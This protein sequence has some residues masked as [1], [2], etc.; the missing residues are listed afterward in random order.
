MDINIPNP[1]SYQGTQTSSACLSQ[2]HD[3]YKLVF[4]VQIHDLPSLTRIHIYRQQDRTHTR[5]HT[6]DLIASRPYIYI[7][8]Y[9]YDYIHI[10]I[11]TSHSYI[12]IYQ[13]HGRRQ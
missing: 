12:Y 5:T 13:P 11:S 10:Y 1:C 4:Q 9:I 8:I 6:S 2:G 3:V 7:Y